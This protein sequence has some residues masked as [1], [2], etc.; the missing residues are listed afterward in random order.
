[1][2]IGSK[3]KTESQKVKEKQCVLDTGKHKR[4]QNKK[5]YRV[6]GAKSDGQVLSTKDNKTTLARLPALVMGCRPR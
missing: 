3:E 2:K 6:A 4:K 5:T 1:M